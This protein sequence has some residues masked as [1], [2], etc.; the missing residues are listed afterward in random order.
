MER[1]AHLNHK[2]SKGYS[3]LTKIYTYIYKY[4]YSWC[5]CCC[6]YAR[7]K[8]SKNEIRN[9]I[10]WAG[11]RAHVRSAPKQ[12]IAQQQQHRSDDEVDSSSGG[13]GGHSQLCDFLV[14]S[15][16]AILKHG[17]DQ[18]VCYLV[19]VVIVFGD[20]MRR[21]RTETSVAYLHTSDGRIEWPPLSRGNDRRIAE[22]NLF[23]IQVDERRQLH[24]ITHRTSTRMHL[25]LMRAQAR[26]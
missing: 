4:I 20:L 17:T 25:Q 18:S 19:V 24:T 1:H 10:A 16:N 15:C 2:T 6:C 5:F 8:G 14:I 22:R 7:R 13:G 21:N 3:I 12:A 9:I 11:V 26:E 23:I